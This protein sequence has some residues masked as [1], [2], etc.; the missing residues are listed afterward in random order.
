MYFILLDSAKGESHVKPT[1]DVQNPAIWVKLLIRLS[2]N[3]NVREKS[4]LI[5][6]KKYLDHQKVYG[7]RTEL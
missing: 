4:Q 3:L 7:K 2:L 6:F 1:N 5:Y